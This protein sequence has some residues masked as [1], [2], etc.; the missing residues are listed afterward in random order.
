[1]EKIKKKYRNNYKEIVSFAK[2]VEKLWENRINNCFTEEDFE[3]IKL[4]KYLAPEGGY[5]IRSSQWKELDKELR[6]FF[7]DK[8]KHQNEWVYFRGYSYYSLDEMLHYRDIK[9]GNQK[10]MEIIANRWKEYQKSIFLIKRLN[11]LNLS[12]SEY[13]AIISLLEWI[14]NDYASIS[15]IALQMHNENFEKAIMANVDKLASVI[16]D[17]VVEYICSS[18]TNRDYERQL[19]TLEEILS[20]R[21]WIFISKEIN[22]HIKKQKRYIFRSIREGDQL[23][24]ILAN[25]E[26]KLIP[27]IKKNQIKKILLLNNAFG[28]I[29]IGYLIK[30]MCGIAIDVMNIYSSV[31]EEEMNRYDTTYNCFVKEINDCY[32]YLVIID[33]SIF[34]GRSVKKIKQLYSDVSTN[35]VCLVMTYDV[36]TYFNHSYELG[37]DDMAWESVCF[38]EQEVRR[39]QGLLTPARSY[40]AYKKGEIS[41]S[42]NNE[43]EKNIKGSD[44]LLRILWTRFEKEI[45]NEHN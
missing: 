39:M 2:S 13:L 7:E 3:G 31:H 14:W 34:T 23:W 20:D 10:A 29:N 8:V 6:Y 42:E 26:I 32:D 22:T 15:W 25:C 41:D 19:G 17:C 38:V 24:I 36:A 35:I 9:L 5:R 1:M 16:I 11:N 4:R 33:D 18:N 43:Y 45:K 30:H 27:W 40:W 12:W 37:D 28:A 21:I 44:L